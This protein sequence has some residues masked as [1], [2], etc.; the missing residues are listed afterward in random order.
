MVASNS[1]SASV[2]VVD[3]NLLNKAVGAL[4]KHHAQRNDD[5]QSSK[6]KSKSKSKSESKTTSLLGNDESIHVQFSLTRIPEQSF[7]SS[8]PIRI[9]IPHS[10]NRLNNRNSNNN[11]AAAAADNGDHDDDIDDDIDDDDDDLEEAEICLIVKDS[12]KAPIKELMSKFPNEMSY[13]KKVLS[14]TSLRKKYAQYSDRRTLCNTYTM[15]L[16]DDSI[17]PMV[18]KLIGKSFFQQKKQPVPVKVGRVLSLPFV[19]DKCI[20]STFLMGIG[21]GTCISVK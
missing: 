9:D 5:E 17:L 19:V 7:V 15:F 16:V 21:A 10:L 12:S 20:R 4:L 13:I 6:S 18:G 3:P 8:R 2:Q 1:S 11:A 14:L